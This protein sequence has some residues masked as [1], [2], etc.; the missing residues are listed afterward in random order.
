M[1]II[2]SFENNPDQDS[3][4]YKG[5]L[6]KKTGELLANGF[7]IRRPAQHN[8]QLHASLQPRDHLEFATAA[9]RLP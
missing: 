1:H 4:S 7:E 8:S 3:M 9:G 6:T 2:K 5:D